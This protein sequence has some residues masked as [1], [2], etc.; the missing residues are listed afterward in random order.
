M[1]MINAYILGA[2]NEAKRFSKE[3]EQYLDGIRASAGIPLYHFYSSLIMIELA[4]QKKGSVKTLLNK[5]ASYQKKMRK[6]G[7][8]APENYRHRFYL[9][10]AE[11]ERLK[12]T[13]EA[14]ETY[15]NRAIEIAQEQGYLHE[16]AIAY[17]LFSRYW[18][19]KKQQDIANFYLKKAERAYMQWGGYRKC[20]KLHEAYPELFEQEIQYLKRQK[21]KPT[22]DEKPKT[23]GVKRYPTATKKQS[24]GSQ[25]VSTRVTVGTTSSSTGSTTKNQQLDISSLM[26][27]S[28]ALSETTQLDDLLRKVLQIAMENAGAEKGILITKQDEQ[29]WVRARSFN[30]SIE[31]ELVAPISMEDSD[32]L[33]VSVVNYVVRTGQPLVLNNAFDNE[34]YRLD[35]YIK[36]AR[37]KSIFC[38]PV[39]SNQQELRCIFY[40]ENNL[41]AN[42]FN[43][44]R[45]KV[46]NMLSAQVA[47]SI[48][49][50]RLYENLEQK[51]AD[52]TQKLEEANSAISEKNKRITDSLRYAQTI[53]GAI[54]PTKSD[55]DRIFEDYFIIYRP[56]DMVS[57]DFYWLAQAEQYT[58]VAVVDCTG[59]G[60]PGAFMSMISYSILN[61][62]VK[63][64]HVY[65]P[66]AILEKLHNGVKAALHQ[67]ESNNADG[68]DIGICRLE[69]KND[70]EIEATFAGA[71]RPLYHSEGFLLHETKGDR[72][73]IGGRRRGKRAPFTNHRILLEK[74]C[75]LYLTTDG[76]MDQC[77]PKRKKLGTLS[78]KRTLFEVAGLSMNEQ[79]ARLA[80]TLDAHQSSA[81]QRDDITIVGLKL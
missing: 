22:K 29:L 11:L 5:V 80:A 2:I 16:L 56:K 44:D 49:N 32:D 62:I 3:T 70:M 48:E 23:A 6:W 10:E 79:S 77:N 39:L 68:M 67:E 61:E 54:L 24:N 81:E 37:P 75:M 17:E 40:L 66:N 47:I 58:F 26:K 52:R 34:M 1:K 73:S 36:Q 38:Y 78:F 14:A 31:P 71:K 53:Q 12:D 72:Q 30:G 7:D 69:Y 59:H 19:D 25:R 28:Q 8:T 42:A 63:E 20:K 45:L 21:S 51:V 33:A 43:Q 50:A 57:G 27:A 76:Y 74:G 65:E 18:E 15:Y 55:M 4:R 35:E 60:V 13:G 41:M 9:V 46:L 64:Q